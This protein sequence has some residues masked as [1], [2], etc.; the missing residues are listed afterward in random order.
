MTEERNSLQDVI[1]GLGGAALIGFALISPFLRNWRTGW[2]ATA[3]ERKSRLPGDEFNPAPKWSFTQ[4]ISIH[5]PAGRV[6]PWLAQ[7]GQGRGGFY[8]YQFLENLIGCK[9]Y[10]AER[11]HPEWQD[12]K[13]GDGIKLHPGMEGLPVVVLQPGRA[14]ALQACM[15]MV[16]G[17]PLNP[18]DISA[19]NY[20]NLI[21]SFTLEPQ[22]NRTSRVIARFSTD[23]TPSRSNNLVYGT[24]L[25]EP[26]SSMMQRK[27]L[28]GLK[29]RVERD[30]KNF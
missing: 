20:V 28:L 19:Q 14:L 16:T 23:F 11:V 29:Q 24:A 3:D 21:W 9:I 4:A 10:N 13:P 7:M 17:K 25:I 1:E 30:E 26:I 22:D 12:V 6:W 8:S 2:G 5:A 18:Q 15:D 27:M